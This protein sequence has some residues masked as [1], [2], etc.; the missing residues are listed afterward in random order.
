MKKSSIVFLV[1]FLG[2]LFTNLCYAKVYSQREDLFKLD[3]PQGWQW[4]EGLDRVAIVNLSTYNSVTIYFTKRSVNSS[5]Q[6]KKVL[7]KLSRKF[8]KRL[9]A[10]DK[11][12]IVE[13]QEVTSVDGVYATRIEYS[14]RMTDAKNKKKRTYYNVRI[15][16]FN[17]GYLFNIITATPFEKESAAMEKMVDS[18]SF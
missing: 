18:F 9:K 5:A 13:K 11:S 4:D 10:K 3:V 1:T 7:S 17:D 12:A 8:V 6:A 14:C 15:S 2:L 16:L